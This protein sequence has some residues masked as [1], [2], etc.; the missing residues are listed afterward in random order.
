[1]DLARLQ[2]SKRDSQWVKY[3][4][5]VILEIPNMRFGSVFLKPVAYAYLI[6]CPLCFDFYFIYSYAPVS[7]M[8][9]IK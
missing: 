4:K 7:Y 5:V 1:M 9:C 8:L 2:P 3:F 6:S